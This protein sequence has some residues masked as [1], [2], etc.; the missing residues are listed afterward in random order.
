MENLGRFDLRAQRNGELI[1]KIKLKQ[2]PFLAVLGRDITCTVPVT[3]YEAILGAEI[4]VPAAV[5]RVRMKVQP[6]SQPGR[7]FRLKGLGL[8]GADQLVTIEVHIPQQL[9]ADELAMFQKL[10]TISKEPNPRESIFAKISS[11]TLPG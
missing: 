2:H 3:I 11:A 8:A 1:A 5:G 7:V 10:R 6:L 9:T 4:E